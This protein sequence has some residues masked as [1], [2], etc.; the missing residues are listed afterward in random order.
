MILAGFVFGGCATT[1]QTPSPDALWTQAEQQRRAFGDFGLPRKIGSVRNIGFQLPVVS[2][3]GEQILCLQ[4]DRDFI[5]LQT[6]FGSPD[7]TDPEGTLSIWLRPTQ[8]TLPGRQISAERWAHSPLWSD[9]GQSIVYVANEP[10]H[11][12]IVHLN[13]VSERRTLLGLA[14]AVNCLPRFDGDDH[15]LLFC[16]GP[17]ATGPFRV[18]RQVVGETLPLPLTPEGFDCL[19]PIRSDGRESVL[20]GRFDGNGLGWVQCRGDTVTDVA[21]N[22]S[23]AGRP[24]ALQALAGITTPISPDGKQLLF[25]NT[26]HKRIAIAHLTESN[27]P[28]HRIGSMAACWVNDETICLATA[29]GMFIVNVHT[30]IT[31]PLLD[32]LWIPCRYVTPTRRL[33]LLGKERTGRLAVWEVVFA[34]R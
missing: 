24:A 22:V 23:Q 28:M 20:C 5:P 29:D 1:Q 9:S 3:D 17:T 15:T 8:G 4:T 13:L 21:R 16:A 26:L 7:H 33:I 25:Y 6:I 31:V 19:W 34:T 30:G 11:S 32:G 14:D 10:D 2:P 27:P 12:V 18:Y